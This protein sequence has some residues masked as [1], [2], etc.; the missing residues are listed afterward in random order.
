MSKTLLAFVCL[1]VGILLGLAWPH[2][3]DPEHWHELEHMVKAK[4]AY[5]AQAAGQGTMKD[6]WGNDHDGF[7]GQ[8]PPCMDS[9]SCPREIRTTDKGDTIYGKAGMDYVNARGGTDHVYGG[10]A[11][12]QMSGGCGSDFV[13]G[14]AGHDHLG[15]DTKPCRQTGGGNDYLNTADGVDEM[16]HI[17]TIKGYDGNDTCV[18][19]EDP[20]DGIMV[21]ECE[22][23]VLKD[24][25]NFSGPTPT[26][27]LHA[28]QNGGQPS[29]SLPGPG[30]YHPLKR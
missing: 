21:D 8:H 25:S 23:V 9:K 5:A 27:T 3:T 1:I 29:G 13:Y 26:L 20:H 2:L 24:L 7:Q 17:E 15:G 4:K 28:A 30:T 19:D 12:D 11:M 16:H 14:E 22:T 18:L 6:D 10:G